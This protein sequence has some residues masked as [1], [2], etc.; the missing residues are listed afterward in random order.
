MPKYGGNNDLCIS[1]HVSSLFA[2]HFRVKIPYFMASN[3]CQ[4]KFAMPIFLHV[5]MDE[6]VRQSG[7][8]IVYLMD[9]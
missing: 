3:I 4:I 7:N 9:I 1:P 2:G 8:F 5:S 6:T